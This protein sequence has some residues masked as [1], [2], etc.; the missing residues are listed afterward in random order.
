[1]KTIHEKVMIIDLV[2]DSESKTDSK[3]QKSSFGGNPVESSPPIKSHSQYSRVRPTPATPGTL[4]C[5]V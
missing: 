1:M 5:E 3:F 2:V 4:I